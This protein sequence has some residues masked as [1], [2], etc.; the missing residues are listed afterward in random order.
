MKKAFDFT[1]IINSRQVSTIGEPIVGPIYH[2]KFP[3]S[4]YQ[5]HTI[6]IHEQYRPDKISYLY[7][8]T[9]DLH[10]VLDVVNNF[11]NGFSEYT[12]G[13]EIKV[14]TLSTLYTMGIIE[15]DEG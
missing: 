2:P 15:A 14:P 4:G 6:K 5:I 11:Y 13:T 8:G 3:I 10:W 7:Y 12:E 1:T 9:T